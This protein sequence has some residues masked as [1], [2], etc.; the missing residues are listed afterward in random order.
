MSLPMDCGRRFFARSL[1]QTKSFSRAFIK[2][3][4]QVLHSILALNFK[5]FRMGAGNCFSRQSRYILVYI[6]K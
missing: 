6:Y 4:V 3:V 2:R 5:I 1:N